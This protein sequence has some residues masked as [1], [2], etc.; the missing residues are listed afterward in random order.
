MFVV[1]FHQD[2]TAVA[3]VLGVLLQHRV[4]GGAG[5]SEGIEDQ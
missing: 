1:H 4:A 2:E 3:A 5:T